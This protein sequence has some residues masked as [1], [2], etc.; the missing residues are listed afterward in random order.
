[1][2]HLFYIILFCCSW[3]YGQRHSDEQGL[4]LQELYRYKE[5]V[6]NHEYTKSV[7]GDSIL[8]YKDIINFSKTIDE[9]KRLSLRDKVLTN[10]EV[11]EVFNAEYNTSQSQDLKI[12]TYEQLPDIDVILYDPN[13]Y[14][15][16]VSIKKGN[17][18]GVGTFAV[19]SMS[20]P[21]FRKDFKYALI[22]ISSE[23]HGGVLRIYENTDKGWVLYKS[24]QLYYI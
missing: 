20:K 7:I 8:L 22:E 10:E 13:K 11:N 14:S 16:E 2:K 9:L 12:W 19:L 17:K 4:I 6:P 21:I 1:M 5:A 23:Y 3:G 24:L 18:I 15:P